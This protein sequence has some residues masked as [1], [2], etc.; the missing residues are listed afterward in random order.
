MYVI[1]I[2]TYSNAQDKNV[3]ALVPANVRVKREV[4]PSAKPRAAILAAAAA[5]PNLFGLTA[6]TAGAAPKPV[7]VAAAVAPSGSAQPPAA[8]ALG[9]PAA[10]P[11]DF[12]AE[13]LDEMAELG[14]L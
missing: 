8:A 13:F 12:F 3:L 7:P 10:N 4:A 2:C 9:A 1:I 5:K 11:D 6:A 14:A